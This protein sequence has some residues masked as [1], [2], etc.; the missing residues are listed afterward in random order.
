MLVYM[1]LA[2]SPEVN[3]KLLFSHCLLLSRQEIRAIAA[4]GSEEW[5]DDKIHN[6]RFSVQYIYSGF[7]ESLIGGRRP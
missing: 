7:T 1:L 5:P 4:F 2:L 3:Q 6:L